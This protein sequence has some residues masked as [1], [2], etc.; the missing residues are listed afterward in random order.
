MLEKVDTEI[1]CERG[2]GSAQ[3]LHL[4]VGFAIEQSEHAWGDYPDVSRIIDE[5]V[6]P[7]MGNMDFYSRLVLAH[8]V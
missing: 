3:A 1:T 8:P 6:V 7:R 2:V 4:I 5:V